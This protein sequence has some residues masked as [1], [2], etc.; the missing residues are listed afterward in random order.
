MRR[1]DMAT[2]A[3]QMPLFADGPRKPIANADVRN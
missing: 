1:R 3:N 2:I